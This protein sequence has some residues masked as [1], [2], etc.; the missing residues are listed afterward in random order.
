MVPWKNCRSAAAL[1]LFI[2]VDTEHTLS[3]SLLMFPKQKTEINTAG[4]DVDHRCQNPVLNS[5]ICSLN[6]SFTD[7]NN[8]LL[9]MVKLYSISIS[10]CVDSGYA[11]H[12]K[13]N[14]KSCKTLFTL[15]IMI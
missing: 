3:L 15:N 10:Y 9:M 5:E 1:R 6:V 7:N 11:I 14:N 12:N 4:F 13:L 8:N 2:V